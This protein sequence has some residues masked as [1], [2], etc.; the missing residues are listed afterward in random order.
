[1]DAALEMTRMYVPSTSAALDGRAWIRE[2][3]AG[4]P[5][6]LSGNAESFLALLP[7][8][9]RR[10]VELVYG[11]GLEVEHAACVMR[12]SEAT[13]RRYLQHAY[14]RAAERHCG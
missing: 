8:R 14:T 13:V 2:A 1:M 4:W 12:I 7:W 6:A 3:L 10:A 9:C 11:R 5:D